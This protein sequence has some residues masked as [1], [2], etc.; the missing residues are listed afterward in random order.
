MSVSAQA[1]AVS[2]AARIADF[3]PPWVSVFSDSAFHV[4]LDTSRVERIAPDSYLIWMQTRWLEPRTGTTKRTPSPFDRE[5]IHTFVRCEL[6]AY[7]VARTIVSL[8]DGPAVDSIG[9]GVDAAR[10]A[11]WHPSAAGSADA[12]AGAEACAL[13]KRM[14]RAGPLE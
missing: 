1:A 2:R 10:Q 7:K 8:D 3:E 5:L 9:A 14:K 12:I 4:A 6:L 13:L 11:D